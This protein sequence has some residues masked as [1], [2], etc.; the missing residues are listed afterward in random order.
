MATTFEPI[1]TNTLSVNTSTITISGFPSTYTDLRLVCFV[2]GTAQQDLDFQFNGDT[3]INYF[4]QGARNTSGSLQITNNADSYLRCTFSAGVPTDTSIQAMAILDI[5]SYANPS[6]SWQKN[7][8]LTWSNQRTTSSGQGD[9][10]V[11]LGSW[12]NTAAIT[13]IL[14]KGSTFLAGSTFTLFGIKGAS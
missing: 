9:L 10:D 2:N 3:G 1:S 13:S 12:R 6:A 14:I 7:V 8:H 5:M 11:H 4:N